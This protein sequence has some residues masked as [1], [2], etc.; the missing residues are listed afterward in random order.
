M[1]AEPYAPTLPQEIDE[2]RHW[3]FAS[4]TRA[5]L[6][7]LDR[8]LGGRGQVPILDVGCGA[9]N[10]VHHLWR[11]GPV[12]GLDS[13]PKPLEVARARGYRVWQGDATAMPFEDDRFGL[14]SVLDTVEHCE[15]DVAVL[16]ECSRVLQPGGLLVLTAP[17]FAWLWSHN[18]DINLHRRRY[19]PAEL[20]QRLE[21]A[22]LQV[23]R[24]TFNNFFAFPLAAALILLRRGRREPDLASPH[25][26]NC[27][28]YQVEMEPASPLVNRVLTQVGKVEAALLRLGNLPIG[29]SL[30][31][32]AEKPQPV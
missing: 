27:N 11:Y 20:R 26:A 32:I 7:I 15:D 14:V 29:T 10:M 13:N 1:S 24:M 3:W 4:R 9:G 5:L 31:A 2:D 28:A 8:E 21:A 25:L 16:R 22:G 18:D 12:V 23:R 30:I 17:A 6:N 19:A